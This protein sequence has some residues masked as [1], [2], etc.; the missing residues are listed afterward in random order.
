MQHTIVIAEAGINHNGDLQIA[1]KLIDGAVLAGADIFKLQKRTINKVFSEEELKKTRETPEGIITNLEWKTK[2]EFTKNDYDIIVE[3]CKIKKIDFMCSPWDLKSVDFL[4]QYNPKYYKI[5]SALLTHREL[6]EK[7]AKL[8]K[9]TFIATGMST[10]E[11]ITKVVSLFKSLET[12]FQLMHCNSSY[13]CPDEDL[14]LSLIPYLRKVFCCDVGYSGHS[15]GIMDGVIATVL[16]A[17]SVEK[18]ITLSRVM[19]GSDQPSSLEIHGL[20]KMIEYIRYVE[21]TLGDGIKRITDKEK[22]VAKK[23]KRIKDYE[24]V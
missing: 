8:G 3:Y 24:Y 10:L 15:A 6:C 21:V 5:P 18:H 14:N 2:L 4:E 20:A 16:G 1:K 23:L 22:E 7:I 9:Y 11:E 19:F 17:K 13:P 12:P